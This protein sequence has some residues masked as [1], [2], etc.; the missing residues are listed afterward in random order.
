MSAIYIMPLMGGYDGPMR[1][2][3]SVLNETLQARAPTST[4]LAYLA[5]IL[6]GEGYFQAT[7]ASR[8][9]GLRVAMVDDATPTWLQSHFGGKIHHIKTHSGRGAVVWTLQRQS[10]IR[11]VLE[12]SMPYFV[13][14][15]PRA[16]AMLRLLDHLAQQ[17]IYE[18]PTSMA[19]RSER[20]TRRA[21]RQAWSIRGQELRRAIAASNYT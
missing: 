21:A 2:A 3:S 14:K 11:Y 7:S 17:P 20:A 18:T 10:D 16:E 15:R 19:T 13:L 5:G 8:S 4:D 1:R 12:G 6:D 9:F